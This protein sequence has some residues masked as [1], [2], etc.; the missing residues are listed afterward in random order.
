MGPVV[1]EIWSGGQKK[2]KVG[3]YFYFS[4]GA[5]FIALFD[6]PFKDST[7]PGLMVYAID[8]ALK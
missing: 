5:F 1:T 2:K 7:E 8:R 4:N 6:P 3:A